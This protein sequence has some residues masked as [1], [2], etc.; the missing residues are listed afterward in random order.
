MDLRRLM[1]SSVLLL[2]FMSSASAEEEELPACGIPAAVLERTDARL[3]RVYDYIR[4]GTELAKLPRVCWE[5][6]EDTTEGFQAFGRKLEAQARTPIAHMPR[7]PLAF[8]LG[9]QACGRMTKIAPAVPRVFVTTRYTV[10]GKPLDP[11]PKVDGLHA[12]VYAEMRA[13]R[14]GEILRSMLGEDNPRVR[15]ATAEKTERFDAFAEAGGFVWTRGEWIPHESIPRYEPPR[16][17]LHLRLASDVK[18]LA[19]REA[20]ELARRLKIPLV[21]DDPVR[22]RRGRAVVVLAG[23]HGIVGRTAAEAARRLD[24]DRS[25]SL[26]AKSVR[27]IRVFVDLNAAERQGLQFPLPFLASAYELEPVKK[28]GDG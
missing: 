3:L 2:V 25:A 11:L 19:F 23:H 21:S 18:L 5:K 20:F 12:V 22:F 9:D 15:L 28:R 24:R 16:A 17:L 14:V 13:E 27:S 4:K 10:N 7:G 1:L 8:V 26:K 6:I